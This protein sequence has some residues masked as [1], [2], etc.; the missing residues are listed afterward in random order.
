SEG[1]YA[2]TPHDPQ[3][4][5]TELKQMIKTLHQLGLRVILDVVFNQV[6]ERENSPFEKT[7][8]GYFFLNDEFG[9]T[10]KGT[11]DVND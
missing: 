1:S 4:R 6:Y 10:S 5:K 9:M 3:T 8:P 2:S 7:V 11:G